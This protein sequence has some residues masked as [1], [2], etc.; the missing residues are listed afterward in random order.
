[1][2]TNGGFFSIEMA[3]KWSDWRKPSGL[4]DAKQR[5]MSLC[6]FCIVS[7]FWSRTSSRIREHTL[8]QILNKEG[9][10]I[11]RNSDEL[12]ILEDIFAN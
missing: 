8:S 5:G 1:M 2:I 6:S 10:I 4:Q 3:W 12:H 7:I 11:E 9:N